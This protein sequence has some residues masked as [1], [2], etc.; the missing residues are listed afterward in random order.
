MLCSRRRRGKFEFHAFCR[1]SW[2]CTSSPSCA[3]A[4][5]TITRNRV[6]S[7]PLLWIPWRIGPTALTIREAAF[8]DARPEE[9]MGGIVAQA[10]RPFEPF[11]HRIEL[12]PEARAPGPNRART[13][14]FRSSIIFAGVDRR[15]IA[16]RATSTRSGTRRKPTCSIT[17]GASTIPS[18]HIRPRA[19]SSS[20]GQDGV[21]LGCC[22]PNR[23]QLKP[24]MFYREQLLLLRRSCEVVSRQF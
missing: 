18:D 15:A 24:P 2:S 23:Q 3:D 6:G 1:E 11:V 10:G 21:C 9:A 17:S 16:R 22:P 19:I 14:Y 8:K 7:L 4:P 20:E 5:E 12:P 13:G